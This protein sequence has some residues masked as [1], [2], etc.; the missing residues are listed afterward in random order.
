MKKNSML[1]ALLLTS[2]ASWQLGDDWQSNAHQAIG[3]AYSQLKVIN[4]E[5]LPALGD[6]CIAFAESCEEL[7]CDMAMMCLDIHHRI[8][9][10]AMEANRLLMDA[11]RAVSISDKELYELC[12]NETSGIIRGV[13]EQLQELGLL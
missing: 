13:I 4:Y 10:L 11:A 12:I 3:V 1:C 9:A 6:A 5:V 8:T 2:C 7:P